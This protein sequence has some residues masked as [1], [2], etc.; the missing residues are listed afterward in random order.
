MLGIAVAVVAGANYEVV[1]KSKLVDLG[2]LEKGEKVSLGFEFVNTSENPLQISSAQAS[3]GCTNLRYPTEEILPG[4]SATI[5]ADFS[6]SHSGVFRKSIQ[7]QIEGSEEV[8]YLYFKG[9]VMN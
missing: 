6:S 9:E 2:Q 8:Y 4:H 1:W 5:A 7:V 3:C